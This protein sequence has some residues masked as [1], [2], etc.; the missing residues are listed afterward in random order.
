MSGLSVR[1]G[2]NKGEGFSCRGYTEGQRL[3]IA[4]CPNRGLLACLC[5]TC[6]F[7]PVLSC[8]RLLDMEQVIAKV[9]KKELMKLHSP[10]AIS[11]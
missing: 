11:S 3:Q 5:M 10:R 8:T 2:L 9:R 6:V 4:S 7:P 1:M